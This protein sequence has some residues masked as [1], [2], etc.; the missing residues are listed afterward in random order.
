MN[1]DRNQEISEMSLEEYEKN[2]IDDKLLLN[3]KQKEAI[4]K[5]SDESDKKEKKR[6]SN[7]ID[8]MHNIDKY[9]QKINKI[10]IRN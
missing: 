9:N 8:Y 2:R 1:I 5:D 7:L 4:E 10:L 3:D 6:Q